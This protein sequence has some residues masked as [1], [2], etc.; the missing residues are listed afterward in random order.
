MRFL[1]LKTP[2]V[3]EKYLQIEKYYHRWIVSWRTKEEVIW[4]KEIIK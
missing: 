2:K 4:W 1:T 3:F